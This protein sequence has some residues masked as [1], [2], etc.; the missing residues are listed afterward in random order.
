MN[1]S[2]V[3]GSRVSNNV[4][5]CRRLLRFEPC[6]DVCGTDAEFVL[7]MSASF[8]ACLNAC[9]TD[10]EFALSIILMRDLEG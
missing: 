5:E 6:L 8:R 1:G 7:S 9:G 4:N 10:V 2:A 3:C